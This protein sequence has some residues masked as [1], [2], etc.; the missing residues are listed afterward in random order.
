[1]KLVDCNTGGLLKL[2]QNMAD[3]LRGQ[4]ITQ[5]KLDKRHRKCYIADT[6]VILYDFIY[7]I[8]QHKSV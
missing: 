7:C 1:M 6:L 3:A 2:H 8:G 5:F 4:D